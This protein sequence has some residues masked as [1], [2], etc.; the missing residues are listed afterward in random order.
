MISKPTTIEL[1]QYE[2]P[3]GESI[4]MSAVVTIQVK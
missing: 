4:R 1:G 3:S 2:L